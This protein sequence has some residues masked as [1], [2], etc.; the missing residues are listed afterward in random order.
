MP[1]IEKPATKNLENHLNISVYGA[2]HCLSVIISSQSTRHNG[3]LILNFEPTK[4]VTTNLIENVWR[5]IKESISGQGTKDDIELDIYSYLYEKQYLRYDQDVRGVPGRRLSTF[6][7]HLKEFHP[8]NPC[9][10]PILQ[11]N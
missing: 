10:T 4:R 7:G 1:F 2:Y 11:V 9:E 6:L 3:N 5:W 8:G